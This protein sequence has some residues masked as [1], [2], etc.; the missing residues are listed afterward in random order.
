[1]NLYNVIVSLSTNIYT[2]I[3]IFGVIVYLINYTCLQ[4]GLI[5]GQ[6][7]LYAAV[8]ILGASSI[9]VSLFDNFNLPTAV[10]QTSFILISILGMLRLYIS[11]NHIRFT[12][13]EKQ[14]IESKFPTLSKYLAR[15]ILNRGQWIK[16]DSNKLIVSE[17]ED[18]EALIYILEGEAEISINGKFVRNIGSDSFIGELTILEES[19]AT[20]TVKLLKSSR[21]FK[22]DKYEFRKLVLRYP[23]IRM[24]LTH[25][26]ANEIKAKL[27]TQTPTSSD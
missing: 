21:Y 14:F 9:L 22:I 12:T 4:M 25:S 24:E 20:A 10:I 11:E 23:E 6:S 15:K 17:G 18:L 13:E 2:I 16:T 19:P 5:S 26:F 3:G 8:V 7:Y 1:M 27:L